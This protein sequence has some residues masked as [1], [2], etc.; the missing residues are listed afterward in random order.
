MVQT[1]PANGTDQPLH[2]RILPWRS[3]CGEHLLHPHS[4]RHGYPVTAVDRIAVAQKISAH[5]IPYSQLRGLH[6][7]DARNLLDYWLRLQA[8]DLRGEVFDIPEKLLTFLQ[9][10]PLAIKI[11]ARLCV[12]HGGDS[13]VKDLRVFKRLREA[14]V[15]VLMDKVYFDR[16]PEGID[17]VRINL[18]SPGIHRRISKVGRR[19]RAY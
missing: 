18:P 13:L 8:H 11:A 2:K 7:T 15:D 5:V 16:R 4:F 14:I 12:T 10:H 17:G 1:F 9:G 3:R 19:D 6:P